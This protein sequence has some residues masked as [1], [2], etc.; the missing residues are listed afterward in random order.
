MF[1]DIYKQNSTTERSLPR[2]ATLCSHLLWIH[3]GLVSEGD[4]RV[5]LIVVKI[6]G[7]FLE[8]SYITIIYLRATPNEKVKT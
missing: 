8:S 4:K 1:I 6:V 3:Y 2:V 5:L 7:S